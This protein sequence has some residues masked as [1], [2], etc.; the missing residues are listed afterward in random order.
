MPSSQVCETIAMNKASVIITTKNRREDLLKAVESAMGQRGLMEVIVIDDGSTDGTEAAV[1]EML[2]KDL[3]TESTENTIEHRGRCEMEQPKVGPRGEG[4]G[5]TES[6]EQAGLRLTGQAGASEPDSLASKLADSPFSESP[7]RSAS[8]PAEAAEPPMT[9]GGEL[10]A[11]TAG[12]AKALDSHPQSPAT[13]YPL[14]VTT[15]PLAWF[16][17]RL[18]AYEAWRDLQKFFPDGEG[19]VKLGLQEIWKRNRFSVFSFQLSGFLLRNLGGLKQRLFGH[20]WPGSFRCG[21]FAR[22]RNSETGNAKLR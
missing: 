1:S 5:A 14:P 18:R 22:I 21:K 13:S 17:F 9:D 11:D 7:T 2:K 4:A 15:A 6:K 10:V 16:G 19:E 3:T 8:D 12:G 20:R